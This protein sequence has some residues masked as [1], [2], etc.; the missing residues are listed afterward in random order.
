VAEFT[1]TWWGDRFLAA[2]SAFMDPGRLARGRSYARNGRIVEHSMA[3]GKVTAKVRG[4]INPYFGVYEEPLYKTT[5]SLRTIPATTWSTVIAGIAANARQVTQL[6]MNE[7]PDTIEAVF[8]EAGEHL[9]PHDGREFK[10]TCSCPD[11][12]SPCKH[13]A[14]VCHLLAGELDDDPFL[15]FELRGLPRE[16]LRGEL[17][18]SPLGKLLAAE[19]E[20][21]EA[22][23][24][25][26]QSFYTRPRRESAPATGL[27]EFWTGAHRLPPAEPSTRSSV[28][29]LQVK[30]QGDFPPFWHKDTSFLAVMEELYERVRTKSPD[31]KS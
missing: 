14:G 5:V 30:K 29:A 31:L 15:L 18:H 8:E 23:L 21:R 4:S 19:I 16:K 20:P 13:V 22:P 10:T 6:L 27:K 26:V 3:N 2:L 28:P 12:Y 9:L 25:T 7:V 1:R 11:Y 24:V 17:E